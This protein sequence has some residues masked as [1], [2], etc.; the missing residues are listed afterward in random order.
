M[1]KFLLPIF[2]FVS[3]QA[4]AQDMVEQDSCVSFSFTEMD[5]SVGDSTCTFITVSNFEN[6]L[7]FQFSLEYNDAFLEFGNCDVDDAI[8]SFKCSDIALQD[9]GTSFKALWFE[10]LGNLTTLEDDTPIA[11]LCFLTIAVPK[12]EQALI[13]FT[14]DLAGEAVK[15]DPNDLSVAAKLPFCSQDDI[16]SRVEDISQNSALSIFPNPVS[17]ILFIENADENSN[18]GQISIYNVNGQLILKENQLNRLNEISFENLHRGHYF[19][20]IDL[21]DE[22]SYSCRFYKE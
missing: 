14:D 9:D 17:D 8:A 6:I 10:P 16:T 2:L 13:Q 7:S 21:N 5:L 11:Q 20:R 3:I 12:K 15:G 19:I 22:T 4:F 1:I 18:I